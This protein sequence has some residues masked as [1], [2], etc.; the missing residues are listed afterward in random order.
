LLASAVVCVAGHHQ[1][2]TRDRIAWARLYLELA[3]ENAGGIDQ[4]VTEM[5]EGD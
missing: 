4:G 2:V 5:I 3:F 1:R